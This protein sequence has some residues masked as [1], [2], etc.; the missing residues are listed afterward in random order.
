VSGGI[1]EAVS[2]VV[3]ADDVAPAMTA[4]QPPPPAGKPTNQSCEFAD[5]ASLER[6]L[7]AYV[8]GNPAFSLHLLL[9]RIGD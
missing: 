7:R 9:K 2:N 3:E 8:A 6:A 4:A 5:R 1:G